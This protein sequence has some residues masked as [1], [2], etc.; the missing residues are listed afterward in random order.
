MT[1]TP[2]SDLKQKNIIAIIGMTGSGKSEAGLFFKE[3]GYPVLRFGDVIDDGIK[4]EGL[5]W[6]PENNVYYRAKI[7]K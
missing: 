3:M 4:A 2:Q 7:R 6:T 1:K 5:H